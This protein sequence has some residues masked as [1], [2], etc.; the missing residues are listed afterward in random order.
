VVLAAAHR[1][2]FS[3]KLLVRIHV[4]HRD[5]SVDGLAPWEFE[6]PFPA[7][8][9]STFLVSFRGTRFRTSLGFRVSGFGLG[10]QGV[11]FR[12]WGLGFGA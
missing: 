9:T 5:N 2:F 6:F 7:S 11:G 4:Y 1:E 12:I 8:L 3:D 10:V